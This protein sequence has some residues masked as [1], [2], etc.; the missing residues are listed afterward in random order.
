MQPC[1][2]LIRKLGQ[3]RLIEP[4]G[5]LQPG[6]VSFGSVYYCMAGMPRALG[7]QGLWETKGWEA[8]GWEAKGW[9]AKGWEAKGWEA[10]GWEAKDWTGIQPPCSPGTD[11]LSYPAGQVAAALI[12]A[13]FSC[14]L[15]LCCP[16]CCH[17]CLILA[18]KK[19]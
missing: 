1:S 19:G 15:R 13:N 8:K 14:P 10:K 3:S 11:T 7:S 6:R 5:I 17:F 9:E 16:K 12:S 18:Q 2:N 4:V